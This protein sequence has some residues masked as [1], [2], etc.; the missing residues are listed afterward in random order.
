M[1]EG[2]ERQTEDPELG[3]QRSPAAE[4]ACRY[5]ERRRKKLRVVRVEVFDH[6]IDRLVSRGLLA[7]GDRF[8][9]AA[10]KPALEKLIETAL[11]LRMMR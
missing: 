4:R 10:L 7:P 2:S 3:P 8:S 9:T 5:R 6:E 1:S 11:A